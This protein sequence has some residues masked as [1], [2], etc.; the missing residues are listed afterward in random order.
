MFDDLKFMLGEVGEQTQI[1]HIIVAAFVN[2]YQ[3]QTVIATYLHILQVVD[4]LWKNKTLTFYIYNI[5]YIICYS[6]FIQL[7]GPH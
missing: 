7:K 6:L 5:I 2:A 4:H 1:H 3:S